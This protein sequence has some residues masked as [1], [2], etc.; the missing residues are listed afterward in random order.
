MI[1]DRSFWTWS[2]LTDRL[3]MI[4][5]RL[6]WTWWTPSTTIDWEKPDPSHRRKQ[7]GCLRPSGDTRASRRSCTQTCIQTCAQAGSLPVAYDSW[8]NNA[9]CIAYKRD[10]WWDWNAHDLGTRVLPGLSTFWNWF[11]DSLK[12]FSWFQNGL[13]IAQRQFA[14]TTHY[15]VHTT[16]NVRAVSHSPWSAS[17]TAHSSHASTLDSLQNLHHGTKNPTF[18]HAHTLSIE[19]LQNING[20][21]FTPGTFSKSHFCWNKLHTSYGLARNWAIA[22]WESPSPRSMKYNCNLMDTVANANAKKIRPMTRNSYRETSAELLTSLC[23]Q[24]GS[25]AEKRRSKRSDNSGRQICGTRCRGVLRA[26]EILAIQKISWDYR[27]RTGDHHESPLTSPSTPWPA[28]S[29]GASG[30][31][32]RRRCTQTRKHACEDWY[33]H[34]A[35]KQQTHIFHGWLPNHKL[36]YL[37]STLLSIKCLGNCVNHVFLQHLMQLHSWAPKCKAQPPVQHWI[38]SCL[39]ETLHPT[40][41]HICTTQCYGYPT[42]MQANKD[43]AIHNMSATVQTD[44][45]TLWKRENAVLKNAICI[46]QAKQQTRKTPCLD[47]GGKTVRTAGTAAQQQHQAATTGES[48]R[49]SHAHVCA[50]ITRVKHISTQ[51]E[52]ATWKRT[53]LKEHSRITIKP[54]HSHT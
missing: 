21:L 39:K 41:T 29:S 17:A 37:H 7:L 9:I 31:T 32:H 44:T 24:C 3:D 4:K 53:N 48:I 38:W 19:P 40:L 51:Q 36:C 12:F 47:H 23:W 15:H 22:L 2:T 43:A 42:K 50:T 49:G 16:T 28:V 10:G 11:Q 33:M 52:K 27:N 18:F 6:F 1:K 25:G 54:T 13:R 34:C 30:Y 5:D 8:V 26:K 14:A 20:D 46:M 35:T 45:Q